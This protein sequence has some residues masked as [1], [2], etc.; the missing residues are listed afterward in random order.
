[1]RRLG[2]Y[3]NLSGFPRGGKKLLARLGGTHE[4]VQYTFIIKV[5]IFLVMVAYISF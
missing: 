1:M 4:V 3:E 5:V 2:G